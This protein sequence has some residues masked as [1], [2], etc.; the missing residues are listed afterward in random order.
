MRNRHFVA[1]IGGLAG[2]A[3]AALMKHDGFR[4]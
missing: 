2:I 1:G 3:A 4:R